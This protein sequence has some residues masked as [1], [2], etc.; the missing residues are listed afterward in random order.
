MN[1]KLSV[2]T[3]G[4][5]L[6]VG[7]IVFATAALLTLDSVRGSLADDQAAP[8]MAIGPGQALEEDV[9]FDQVAAILNHSATGRHLLELKEAYMIRVKFED[10]G[11]S[12]F[13]K[14]T[15]VIFLDGTHTPVKAAL[16]FA[17]E[18]HH[19]RTINAGKQADPVNESRQA[20][21]NLK[22][23]EEVEGMMASFQVKMELE[24]TGIDVANI[25]F[26]LE[27]QY[28]QAY[29]IATKQALEMDASLIEQQL[30]AIGQAAGE[31]ALFD[32]FAS[33]EIE[34]SNTF[35]PY[36]EYF[37]RRWDEAQAM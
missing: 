10:G 12:R 11:G 22:L 33:G 4:T 25:S 30:D 29:L 16:Y 31:Q 35:E 37:E 15:N 36:P 18:M 34:T 24:K 19:A 27:K 13:R 2:R 1:R 9:R 5:A 28:R 20:Y 6:L 32:A 17:H 26:P 7:I 8:A 14:R 23:Q 21:I 3:V